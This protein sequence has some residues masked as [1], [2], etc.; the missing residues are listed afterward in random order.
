MAS[1]CAGRSVFPKGEKKKGQ[2]S[3][4]RKPFGWHAAA[5]SETM[6]LL[7]QDNYSCLKASKRDP[8]LY[9]ALHGR[10]HVPLKI[11]PEGYF[12]VPGAATF[13]PSFYFS[14]KSFLL[15]CNKM[16][17]GKHECVIF[18]HHQ[19]PRICFSLIDSCL[20]N[21]G[22]QVSL[23]TRNDRWVPRTFL[24]KI[25]CHKWRRSL[26]CTSWVGSLAPYMSISVTVSSPYR[27]PHVS[28]YRTYLYNNC[29]HVYRHKILWVF[30]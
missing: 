24:F 23:A 7:D 25:C 4:L 3:F 1:F 2:C 13:F 16:V 22:L 19:N 27:Q 17:W 28:A 14:L 9:L 15:W 10:G 21:I 12:I 30:S 26:L 20:L 5:G 6:S 11:N 29:I 18:M 8:W